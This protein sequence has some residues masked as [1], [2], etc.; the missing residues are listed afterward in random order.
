MD[1]FDLKLIP[2]FDGS[3]TSPSIVIWSKKAKHV[4]KLFRIKEPVLVIP[5]R[6]M[7]GT[8]SVYQ[9]L[10]EKANLDEIKHAFYTAFGT[11]ESNAWRQFIGR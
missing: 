9:Q 10:K 4:C 6:L 7:G 11:D 5:L 8:Y 3:P 1:R 2:E